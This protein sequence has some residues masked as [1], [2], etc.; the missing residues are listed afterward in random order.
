MFDRDISPFLLEAAKKMP[1]IAILGPRQ[2]GKTT[3]AKAVFNK[4]KYVS[5][6]NYEERDL[7]SSDPKRFLQAYEN[8]HGVIFDE[9]QHV[10]K[11]LSYIQTYVD[12]EH[13]PGHIV[14][15]G[16]QNIL[17]N[18]GISQTLAG[19]ISLFTLLPLSIEE[20]K[21]NTLLQDTVDSSA[22]VGGY[23]RIYAYDLNPTSWYSDYIDTYVEKDVRQI[24]NVTNLATFKRFL[25]ICAGRTGQ[26]INFTSLANDSSIDVRTAKQWLSVLEASYILFFLQPHYMNFNKRLTQTPKLYFYDTGLVCALLGIESPEQLSKYYQRGGVIETS[27]ISSIMKH[28]YNNGTR[29]RHVYF[30]RDKTGHE[31]DCMIQKV[32]DL[33]PIEIKSGTTITSDF[34]TGLSYWQNLTNDIYPKGYVIYGGSTNFERAQGTLISWKNIEDVFKKIT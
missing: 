22:F 10:P 7:A 6:E 5:L 17:L 19:R 26:L 1:V 8:D 28:Y 13:K 14:L 2:S 23:P 30:W 16:S 15:T 3:L 11:L 12:Q 27:I 31:I 24:I 25:G 29:P 34:F 33:I 21:K 9:I 32:N 4:H 18:R 20:L